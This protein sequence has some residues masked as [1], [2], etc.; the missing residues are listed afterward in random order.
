MKLPYFLISYMNQL[1]PG[2]LRAIPPLTDHDFTN[3]LTKFLIFGI[4]V[5]LLKRYFRGRQFN[6]PKVNLEGRYAVVTGG[7][8]GIGAETV[9]V[10]CKLGCSVVIGARNK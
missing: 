9:K 3:L 8:S 4:V 5:V 6:I 7:N 10:L 2:S 1:D